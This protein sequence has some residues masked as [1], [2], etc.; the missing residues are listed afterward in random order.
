M[1]EENRQLINPKKLKNYQA[2]IALHPKIHRLLQN[3]Q[4]TG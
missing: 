3:Y 1:I 4:E 2:F